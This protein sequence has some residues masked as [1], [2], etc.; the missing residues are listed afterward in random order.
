MTIPGSEPISR[1]AIKCQSIA[2]SAQCPMPAI[3]VSGTACAM[4]EPT[5]RDIGSCG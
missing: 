5:M 4:S 1:T 2:P 3:S